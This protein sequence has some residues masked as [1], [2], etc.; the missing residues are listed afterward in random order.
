VM[1]ASLKTSLVAGDTR[2]SRP[3]NDS[4]YTGALQ[5]LKNGMWV[6]FDVASLPKTCPIRLVQMRERHARWSAARARGGEP[7]RWLSTIRWAVSPILL[8]EMSGLLR[9]LNPPSRD[10]SA[11]RTPPLNRGPATQFCDRLW[12]SSYRRGQHRRWPIPV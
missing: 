12:L 8:G 9:A 5:R 7:L 4:M 10:A 6:Q 2:N 11:R 3:G 1:S